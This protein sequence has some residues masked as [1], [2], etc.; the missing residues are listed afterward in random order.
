MGLAENPGLL[1]GQPVPA[2]IAREL[3]SECGSM[4]RI[5][6]DPLTAHMLDYGRR[7]YLPEPL[8]I[9]TGARDGT[10]RTPCC[11]QPATRSQYDHVVPFPVGPSDPANGQT[12]CK[13]DHDSKTNGDIVF[14]SH[15]ADGSATWRTRHGQTG[16]TPP[17]PYLNDP[18]DDHGCPF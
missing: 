8:K 11:G 12:A 13:R 18:A 10:C 5:I 17:R 3:V 7:V 4:R 6:T 14:T 15:A 9:F 1:N 2:E 16:S